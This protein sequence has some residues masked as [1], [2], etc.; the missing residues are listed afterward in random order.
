MDKFNALGFNFRDLTNN[1]IELTAVP[2]ILGQPKF[3]SF[4]MELFDL[5]SSKE[6]ED[7]N[8]VIQKIISISCKKAVKAGDDLSPSEISILIKSIRDENIPLSCPHGRPFVMKIE[9]KQ[10]DK[11]VGRI[12]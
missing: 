10:I 1:S 5:L 6:I 4:F 12:Q 11:K 7:E 8:S 9:R 3:Q 2:H